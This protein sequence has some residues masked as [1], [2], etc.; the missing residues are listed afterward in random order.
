MKALLNFIEKIKP[1]FEEGGKYHWLWSTFE[2]LET[3]LFVP[4]TVT[5]KGAHIRDSI[6][7]KRTMS[8]VVIATLPALIFGMWNVGYQHFLSL[9]ESADFWQNF[10]F[11]LKKVLPIIIVS[12]AVGLG[13]E[14]YFAQVR[15]HEINEGYLVTGM[16]IP[17]I[18]PPDIPLWIVAVAVAF[19]VIFGKEVF[20]GTGMNVVNPALLARAFL[21]FAYPGDMSGDKVWIAEKA[22]GYSGATPL[23]HA[24]VGDFGH[25]PSLHD[26]F[27]GFIPGSVGETST[28]M[29][30]IGAAILLFTG[31]ASW[32]IMLTVFAGGYVMGLLFNLWGANE[33]MELPAYYH[34][35]MGGFAF[36]AVFMA[37]DPVTSAQ[38]NR[39]KYLY[40]F[41]IGMIAVLI[42]VFNPAYPEGMM[43]AILLM[44]VFAPLIDHYVIESNIKKR[45]KRVKAIVN[46]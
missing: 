29:I 33:Y 2:G 24:L 13:I 12:Y 36:G 1:N 23:G 40:G 26:M 43:L 25:L 42:R 14:F 8:V 22:D 46:S 19:A 44:N 35:V 15:G 16:L 18:V 5:T 10:L 4:N 41:L 7:M 38:T 3:F 32:R 6:D 31:I 37:T 20:G 11:G 17:L 27:F 21:F 39:G 9:S 30:L 34:L 45:L 28:L